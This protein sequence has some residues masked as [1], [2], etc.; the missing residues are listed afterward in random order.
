MMKL[1]FKLPELNHSTEFNAKCH[2]TNT[3]FNY[4]L[5]I[6]R[7]ILHKLDTFFNFE[8]K[9]VTEQ[10]VSIPMKLPDCTAKEFFVIKECRPV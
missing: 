7:D 9:T 6:G 3:L 8:T 2:S 5:I 4:G 10:E 1:N